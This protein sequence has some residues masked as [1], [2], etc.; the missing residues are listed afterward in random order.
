MRS[1]W[2]GALVV[3][4]ACSSK[5]AEVPDAAVDADN[6]AT[7]LS[8]TPVT[9]TGTSPRGALDI[10]HY[11]YAGYIS[12]D[13]PEAYLINFTPTPTD[14]V[15]STAQLQLA[16]YPPFTANGSNMASASW[17]IWSDAMTQNV[18]FEATQLDL[19]DAMAPRIQGHFVS[20]DPAW[21]FDIPVDLT[22]QW[23]EACI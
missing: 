16:I 11:A 6:C 19:P 10:F 18:T 20:H 23:S 22:S 12:G 17:P 13:C 21:S 7:T 9:V 3:V 1:I 15:C 8:F 4:A 5:P 14:P 2:L